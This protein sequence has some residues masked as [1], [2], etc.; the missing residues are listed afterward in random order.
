VLVLSFIGLHGCS[1]VEH[2]SNPLEITIFWVCTDLVRLSAEINF[3]VKRVATFIGSSLPGEI[4]QLSEITD[5]GSL[6][7]TTAPITAAFYISTSFFTECWSGVVRTSTSTTLF[8][9][10]CF[11]VWVILTFRLRLTG[12]VWP[13]F[14]I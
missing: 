8:P 7:N 10:A 2:T 14:F 12:D 11:L 13:E 5:P 3:G 9:S 6:D 1:P 4:V